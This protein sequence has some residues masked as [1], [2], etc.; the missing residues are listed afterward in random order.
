VRFRAAGNN[1]A[2]DVA[3][4]ATLNAPNG[5]PFGSGV[6]S[7]RA[8]EGL[9]KVLV[10]GDPVPGIPEAVDHQPGL[11]AMSEAGHLLV[12][13]NYFLGGLGGQSLVLFNPDGSGEAV[14]RF[15]ETPGFPGERA[16]LTSQ[17]DLNSRGDAIFI[18]SMNTSAQNLAAFAYLNDTDELVPILKTGDTLDG[19]TVLSFDLGGGATDVLGSI[20][21]SGGPVSWDDA[22]NLSMS[23]LLR[24]AAGSRRYALYAVQVPE[25]AGAALV[26]LAA[27]V[28]SR[29]RLSVTR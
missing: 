25:P 16:G 9:T 23:V 20:G 19:Q 13:V 10:H 11:M 24:D 21:A 26:G 17:A 5:T 12:T 8:G 1:Q 14:L 27:W 15:N 7:A 4:G 29:W 22:R 3:F 6:F 2:G 18:T 28:V